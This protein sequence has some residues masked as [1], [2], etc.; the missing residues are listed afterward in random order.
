MKVQSKRGRGLEGA[1]F[2]EWAWF[3]ENGVGL[4]RSFSGK[5]GIDG[6]RRGLTMMGGASVRG[7]ANEARN[8]G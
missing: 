3:R 8:V 2:T 4:Q 1:W 7:G 5:G 6:R